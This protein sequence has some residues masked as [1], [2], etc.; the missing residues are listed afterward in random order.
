MQLSLLILVVPSNNQ[1]EDHVCNYVALLYTGKC[2]GNGILCIQWFTKI[3]KIETET[4]V[5]ASGNPWAK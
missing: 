1:N 5:C 2:D 4:F 3:Q